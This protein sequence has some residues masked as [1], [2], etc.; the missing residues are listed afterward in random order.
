MRTHKRQPPIRLER[1]DHARKKRGKVGKRDADPLARH[2]FHR[3]R[4]RGE[5]GDE[6][7]RAELG[8]I[9]QRH[10]LAQNRREEQDTK[11]P[12]HALP[13]EHVPSYLIAPDS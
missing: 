3:S 6:R 9:K 8:V 1:D 4:V 10:F 7:P 11:A 13:H 2:R 12:R 5:P